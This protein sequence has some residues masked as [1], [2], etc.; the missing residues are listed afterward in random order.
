MEA[1]NG[2]KMVKIGLKRAFFRGTA[3]IRQNTPKYA[4]K[5]L[6]CLWGVFVLDKDAVRTALAIFGDKM[7]LYTVFRGVLTPR[8]AVHSRQKLVEN[9]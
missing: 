3:K 8:K 2:L 9:R 7:W 6:F 4:K 5:R 1:K